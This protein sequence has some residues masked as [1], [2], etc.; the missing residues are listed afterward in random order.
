MPLPV[1]VAKGRILSTAERGTVEVIINPRIVSTIIGEVSR[2]IARDVFI[3]IRRYI[4]ARTIH[5]RVSRPIDRDIS[6]AINGSVSCPI[7]RDISLAINNSVVSHSK[8]LIPREVSLA[9]RAQPGV[10][11]GHHV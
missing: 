6:L 11:I 3:A 2:R 4:R 10:A 7:D 1:V 8:L 5:L 9:H